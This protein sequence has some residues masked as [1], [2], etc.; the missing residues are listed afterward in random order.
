MNLRAAGGA[1]SIVCSVNTGTVLTS[2]RMSFPAD[3]R[4]DMVI[5]PLIR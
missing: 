1:D 4:C 2:G 3:A 5:F